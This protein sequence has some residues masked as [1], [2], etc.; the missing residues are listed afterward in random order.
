MPSSLTKALETFKKKPANEKV[1]LPQQ[2]RVSPLMPTKPNKVVQIIAST[3]ATTESNPIQVNRVA[4]VKRS[5]MPV[6]RPQSCGPK[7]KS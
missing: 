7:A 3:T 6:K 4:A 5:K 1:Y 2:H